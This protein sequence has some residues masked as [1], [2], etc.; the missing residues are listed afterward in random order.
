MANEIEIVVKGKDVSGDVVAKAHQR[1][2]DFG[3]QVTDDLARSGVQAG[4]RFGEGFK[5]GADGRLR[6]SKG[7]FVK[8]GTEAGEGFEQGFTGGSGLFGRLMGWLSQF[9]NSVASAF[10]GI[11]GRGSGGPAGGFAL[12]LLALV[13]AAAAAE[14]ALAALAPVVFLVGGAFGSAATAG[15]G[16]VALLGTLVLGFGGL[17]DAWTAY[18]Q[19]SSGGGR[20]AAMAA[21]EVKAATDALADAQRAALR[22]QEDVTRARLN[23][24]ERLEDLS[25]SLAGARLDE[26]G[27]VL[28]VQRAEQRLRDARRGGGSALDY[29]EAELG[30][31]QARQTLDE[32]RDRVGDLSKEQEDAN[33]KG[34]E[35]SDQVQAAL[36]RQ[37]MA[38]RQL[39]DATARLAESQRGAGGGVDRFAEAMAGLSA[40]GQKLITTLIGLKPRFDDLKKSVQDRMLAGLDTT[41]KNL[42]SA[43]FPQLK[44]SLGGLADSVNRIFKGVASTL[45]KPK[46]L[47]DFG[48][49][50]AGFGAFMERL[51]RATEKM[52]GAIGTLAAKSLPFFDKLGELIEG[53]LTNFA[54]WIDEAD[55]TGKLDQFMQDAAKALEDIWITGGLV[56]DIIG[57]LIEIFLPPSKKES[58]TVFAGLKETLT[59]I[60]DWLGDPKNQQMVRDWVEDMKTFGGSLSKVIGYFA[61]MIDWAVFATNAIET[62]INTIVRMRVR[63][64]KAASGMFDGI[65][66]AF[67]SALNWVIDRWNGL[68]LKLP[69]FNWM[70]TQIGGATL[71][72]PDI[73]RFAHGGIGGGLA[74]V[75]E[76]GRELIQTPGGMLLA[77]PHGSTVHPNGTTE[78]MLGRG[79]GG[80]VQVVIDLVGADAD[81]RRRI[82]KMTKVHGGGNVQVAF[83]KI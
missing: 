29:R 21:R 18:G 4:E 17:G 1:F 64:D 19:K 54:E 22:A 13:A 2:K 42:V 20:S 9:A 63:M 40:N 76:R 75:A 7:R 39:A 28:A 62:F 8:A 10:S 50:T 16:L 68:E 60:R 69:G 24:Q 3:R 25:R 11:F 65:K 61:L 35:G 45:S 46:F 59:E 12:T 31:R 49:A 71:G 80:V 58:D 5:R 72:T 56:K 41:L 81:L 79:S 57:E 36:E 6:D 27:A 82:Q 67:R 26:E 15:V 52:I 66:N 73:P 38:Q 23:E 30:L 77:M 37:R 32:V 33:R 48:I 53:T 14:V 78:A 43:T 55:R 34:V 74:R 83:G 70:G 47:T 51:G 44:T